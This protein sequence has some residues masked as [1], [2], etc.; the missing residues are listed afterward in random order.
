MKGVYMMDKAKSC[1]ATTSVTIS[2]TPHKVN[3]T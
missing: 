1:K 2:V 3:V